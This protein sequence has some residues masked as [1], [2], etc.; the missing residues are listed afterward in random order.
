MI[1]MEINILYYPVDSHFF[2]AAKADTA[3]AIK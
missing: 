2:P 1:H 3:A